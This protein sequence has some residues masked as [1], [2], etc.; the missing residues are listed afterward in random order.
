MP[1]QRSKLT[2]LFFTNITKEKRNN[3]VKQRNLCATL[4]QKSKIGFFGSLN[5]TKFRNK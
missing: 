2:N 1:I 5:K 3:Y 4:S